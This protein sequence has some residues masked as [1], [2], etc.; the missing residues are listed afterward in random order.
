M[1]SIR[2]NGVT[3]LGL[4]LLKFSYDFDMIESLRELN[5]SIKTKLDKAT[6]INGWD[7]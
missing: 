4:A 7:L 3:I 2:R 5:F 1:I 6:A